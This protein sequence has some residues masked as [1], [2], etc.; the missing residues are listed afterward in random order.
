MS[1]EDHEG[2]ATTQKDAQTTPNGYKG[3]YIMT[4]P[5][6]QNEETRS[7]PT[8]FLEIPPNFRGMYTYQREA[9]EE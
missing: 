9:N 3:G 2:C 4:Q 7:N 5:K 8:S 1:S 6:S